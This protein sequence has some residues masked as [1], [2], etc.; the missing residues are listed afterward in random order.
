MSVFSDICLLVTRSIYV[1]VWFTLAHFTGDVHN[2]MTER[3][4]V[5]VD[6]FLNSVVCK[7]AVVT[8]GSAFHEFELWKVLL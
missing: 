1:C 5:V 2:N 3:V 6:P 7:E 8:V 4:T